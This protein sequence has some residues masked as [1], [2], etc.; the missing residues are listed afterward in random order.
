MRKPRKSLSLMR[1]CFTV[2]AAPS[3]KVSA[4]SVRK[5][6]VSQRTIFGCQKAPARFFPAARSTAVLPPTEESDAARKVVGIWI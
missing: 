2:S 1:A 3:A 6:S 5:V 4:G